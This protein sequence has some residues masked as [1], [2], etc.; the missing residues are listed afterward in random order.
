MLRLTVTSWGFRGDGLCHH[1]AVANV[2]MGQ[3]TFVIYILTD[4]ARH[5]LT[6]GTLDVQF[7]MSARKASLSGYR[8]GN[9]SGLD[10]AGTAY[11]IYITSRE[12]H[13]HP[14]LD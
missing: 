5:R 11:P 7:A 13:L 6:F 8:N 9:T 12:K 1:R 2:W 4:D 10:I 14:S 3:D